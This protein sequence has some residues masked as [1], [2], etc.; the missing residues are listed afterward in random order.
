MHVF[1]YSSKQKT[2]GKTM[3]RSLQL[4]VL[5]CALCCCLAD[6]VSTTEQYLKLSSTYW[7]S[8]IFYKGLSQYSPIPVV[9]YPLEQTFSPFNVFEFVFLLYDSVPLT[10]D[11]IHQHFFKLSNLKFIRWLLLELE[12]EAV[13]P[14]PMH[15]CSMFYWSFLLQVELLRTKRG[16]RFYRGEPYRQPARGT[17]L[18]IHVQKSSPSTDTSCEPH[19]TFVHLL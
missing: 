12:A 9:Y 3:T 13:H 11:S 8:C 6:N 10:S 7:K 16:T 17:L 19:C 15:V 18:I 14:V 4:I 1:S 5:L 2:S